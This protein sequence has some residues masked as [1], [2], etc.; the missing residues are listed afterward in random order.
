MM[1]WEMRQ[2]MEGNNKEWVTVMSKSR[3]NILAYSEVILRD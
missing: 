1:D 3:V 2:G